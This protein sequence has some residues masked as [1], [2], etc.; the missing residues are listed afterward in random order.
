[1]NLIN[2]IFNAPT[3]TGGTRTMIIVAVLGVLLEIGTNLYPD[4]FNVTLV[5]SIEG[6]IAVIFIGAASFDEKPRVLE[7]KK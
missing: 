5:A 1:M 4:F 2:K 3:S 6:L 7:K